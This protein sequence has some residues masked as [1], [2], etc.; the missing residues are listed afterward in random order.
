[1]DWVDGTVKKLVFRTAKSETFSVKTL[2]DFTNAANLIILSISSTYLAI[3]EML[4][5]P[6]KAPNAPPIPETLQIHE[7]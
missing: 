1:M 5:E 7:I 4:D 6:P 2:E 3:P